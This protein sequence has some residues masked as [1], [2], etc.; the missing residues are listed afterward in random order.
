M[1]L[2]R[3]NPVINLY[4]GTRGDLPIDLR[5]SFAV[6]LFTEA[7]M[8]RPLAAK[9]R[10]LEEVS[11]ETERWGLIPVMQ[12]TRIPVRRAIREEHKT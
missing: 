5:G 4:V 6:E 11:V 8:C 9:F 1:Q 12:A 2:T 3:A 10:R 7:V